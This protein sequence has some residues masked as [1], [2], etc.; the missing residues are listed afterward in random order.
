MTALMKLPSLPPVPYGVPYDMW[1]R[2]SLETTSQCNR[3]CHFCPVS[4]RPAKVQSMSDELYTRIVNQLPTDWDG[5]VQWFF[6]NEPLFDKKRHQ[7]IRQLRTHAPNCTI[8]VTTNWEI[9][10][11]KSFDDQVLEA[12][13]L[14]R[15]G[16]SSLNLNAYRDAAQFNSYRKVAIHASIASNAEFI[17]D[18][19]WKRDKRPRISAS[20]MT[21]PVDLHTW[22]GFYNGDDVIKTRPKKCP[23]AH[24]HL[25]VM[26]DGKVPLCCAVNPTG[27]EI[28]G[29]ANIESLND[30]WNSRRFFEYRWNLQNGQRKDQCEG[31]VERVSFPGCVHKVENPNAKTYHPNQT[32]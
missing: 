23:R 31:C 14:I 6:V 22:S 4:Q 10:E 15:S 7:R 11:K 18:H 32:F 9:M 2:M 17:Y 24:K 12:A 30:I 16:V 25:V 28:L 19:C 1:N 29:D 5:T 26:W 8:H 13:N 27:A 20:N 3:R 21:S